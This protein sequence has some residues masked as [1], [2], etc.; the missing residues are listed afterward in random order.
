VTTMRLGSVSGAYRAHCQIESSTDPN[1]PGLVVSRIVSRS[2]TQ[3]CARVAN[4]D[5]S[6]TRSEELVCWGYRWGKSGVYTATPTV[7]PTPTRTPTP[8][9]T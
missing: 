8:T 4:T 3:V 6:N 1:E 9:P 5:T 2:T 7:T